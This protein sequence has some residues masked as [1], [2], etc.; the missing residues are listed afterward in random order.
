MGVKEEIPSCFG[1]IPKE[2]EVKCEKKKRK[3]V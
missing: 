1:G 3:R 2:K